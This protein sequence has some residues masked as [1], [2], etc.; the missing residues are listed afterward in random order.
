VS[1]ELEDLRIN[2]RP[3]L[4]PGAEAEESAAEARRRSFRERLPA[5]LTP[6]GVLLL[7]LGAWEL[8]TATGWQPH[9]LLPSPGEIGESLWTERGAYWSNALT[10]L[11]EVAVGFSIGALLGVLF[12]VA[13]GLVSGFRR[14]L[15]PLLVA[16]QSLPVLALAP[17]LVL[18]FG[19]G[20]VPKL[21]IIVQIVFF[22]VTVATISGLV[23]VSEEALVFGRSLGA[24]WSALFFKVRLP[25]SLPFIFS[26]LKISAS[27]AAIAAV[28]AEW[29]GST[30]GLGAMMLR[31]NTNLQTEVVFGALVLI[32][33]IGLGAFGLM[34]LLERILVPWHERFRK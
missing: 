32:T 20:I 7:V 3:Q 18:W 6:I 25:A 2:P 14:A 24:S 13:I 29:A 33:L 5:I 21:I 15:Y 34:V 16:S 17:L 8:A 23:S 28:I 30:K 27:Y 12:G 10:T 9:Y 22:P 26:G 11:T 4:P 1:I 19:F 31:A